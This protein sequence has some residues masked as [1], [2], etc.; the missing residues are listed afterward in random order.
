[1]AKRKKHRKS[2]GEESLRNEL[3][4]PAKDKA[5]RDHSSETSP[6]NQVDLLAGSA[7]FADQVAQIHDSRLPP[8][9]RQTLA[10]QIGQ[11]QG[12][13][14]L[15]RVIA[16][17]QQTEQDRP[18]LEGS[19][20]QIQR[21]EIGDGG[22]PT[23]GWQAI[24]PEH[25]GR[26]NGAIAI[27]DRVVENPRL[28]NYFRDHSP[29]GT[30][31]TLEEVADRAKIWEVTDEGSLGE[32]LEGGDDMAYDPLIFR[33][34]RW[35]IAATLLH[36]M[37]HLAN[38]ATEEEC[39]ETTEVGRTYAPFITSVSPRRARVGDEVV[40]GGISFGLQ[41]TAID[42]VEFNGVD[43]GRA[44]SW[45][46]QHDTQGQIHIRVPEGATSGPVVVINN[47]VRSNPIHL[48]VLP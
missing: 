2:K 44:I 30:A 28:Q 1:M 35:Q 4:A 46:W 20:T 37:G 17:G 38:F 47:N 24:T 25:E 32:S 9:Q 29:G 33:I 45:E 36:E 10:A 19:D 16:S 8:A 18:I 41:Q 42:R 12:N 5:A 34:G 13:H 11:V 26:V 21:F 6:T 3:R 15:Q 23:A 40:I 22:L 27:L 43:G 7:T 39:E 31:D 14:H 48:T